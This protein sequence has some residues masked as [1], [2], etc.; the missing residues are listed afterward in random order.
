MLTFINMAR[1][2]SDSISAIPLARCKDRASRLDSVTDTTA[3][4]RAQHDL[5]VDREMASHSQYRDRSLVTV[6]ALI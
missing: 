2:H 1:E 3:A 6:S 4:I 5:V